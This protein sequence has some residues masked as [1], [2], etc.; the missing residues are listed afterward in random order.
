MERGEKVVYDYSALNGKIVATFKTQ[1][2]FANAI[3]LSERSVSLKMNN[4]IGWRQGEI[5]KACELLGITD[6]E[7]SIYFFARNVQV[8]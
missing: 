7:I 3:G 8:N 4:K 6:S 2:K 1:Q 5:A